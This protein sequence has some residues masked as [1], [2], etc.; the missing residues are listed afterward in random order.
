MRANPLR[1]RPRAPTKAASSRRTPKKPHAHKTSMG[2]P[3]RQKQIPRRPNTASPRNDKVCRV[4][5]EDVFDLVEEAGAALDGLV[6]DFYD[7]VQLLEEGFLL[8]G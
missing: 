6:F 8:L 5:A 3:E 4:L 2:H 7:A 1:Y